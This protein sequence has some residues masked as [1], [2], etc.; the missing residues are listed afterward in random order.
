MLRCPR[1]SVVRGSY[2]QYIFPKRLFRLACALHINTRV[3]LHVAAKRAISYS[4]WHLLYVPYPC[5]PRIQVKL[6]HNMRKTRETQNEKERRAT[7][8]AVDSPRA[9]CRYSKTAELSLC[10]AVSFLRT[11]RI[12]MC[13]LPRRRMV[14]QVEDGPMVIAMPSMYQRRMSVCL[15]V[16]SCIIT[17]PHTKYLRLLTVRDKGHHISALL[18]GKSRCRVQRVPLWLCH[19]SC[20]FSRQKRLI[21]L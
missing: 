7:T 13:V 3:S 11:L 9:C 1:I 4:S 12:R 2:T 21:Q 5:L 18:E 10:P 8:T 17:H 20:P 6:F 14:Q 16:A 15:S 19:A